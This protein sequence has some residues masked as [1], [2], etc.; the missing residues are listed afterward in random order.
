MNDTWRGVTIFAA[1]VLT[2]WLWAPLSSDASRSGNGMIMT[3][4]Y[5]GPLRYLTLHTEL[6][7]PEYSFQKKLDAKRL[8]ATGGLTALLWIMVI[9]RVRK[10]PLLET[11]LPESAG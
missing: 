7:E 6:K 8:V 1:A 3:E 2:I 10:R 4:T 5:F 9:W 11:R